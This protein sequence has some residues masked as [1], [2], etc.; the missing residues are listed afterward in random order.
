MTAIST[1]GSPVAGY[2]FT[3]TC[4][5]TVTEGLTEIPI[6]TWVDSS[7]QSLNSTGDLIVLEQVSSRQATN[8]TLYFD[9]LRT[10]DEGAYRCI[11]TLSS[12]AL[13]LPLNSSATYLIDAQQSKLM[14]SNITFP[15]E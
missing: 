10:S 7:G 2:N 4:T 15:L 9:P 5:V 8:R 14:Y 11:V 12:P 13:T 6:I 1:L 3:L